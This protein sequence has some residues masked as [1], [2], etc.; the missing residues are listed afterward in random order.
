MLGF[1]TLVTGV[2]A[3]TEDMGGGEA[4]LGGTGGGGAMGCSG[5]QF[6]RGSRAHTALQCSVSELLSKG[7]WELWSVC[8]QEPASQEATGVEVEM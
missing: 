5:T 2:K 7:D 4:S 8:E 6:W 3:I 1:Q